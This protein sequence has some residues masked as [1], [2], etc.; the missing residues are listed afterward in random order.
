MGLKLNPSTSPPDAGSATEADTLRD[1]RRWLGPLLV[2]AVI[3][4]LAMLAQPSDQPA[5]NSANAA[6]ETAEG[7]ADGQGNT[8]AALARRQQDDPAALGKTDAP[9]VV[10]EYS[11][12]QCSFCSQHARVTSPRL[13]REYVDK[14]LVRI[15]WRDLP[16]L[17]PESRTAAAAGRAAGAQGKFWEFHDA[18]YARDGRGD[19]AALDDEALRAIATSIGLDLGRFEADRTSAA[20]HA[21]IERDTQEAISMGLTG[22]P[23]FIIGNTPIMGA[24]PYEVFQ[25]IIVEQ[26]AA[27]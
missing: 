8:F 18:V 3:A 21:A 2:I 15:E 13:I 4:M 17:G 10:I 11:D 5:G 19:S 24:Q 1:A 7:R 6:T 12:F 25:R 27:K 20:I 22:T 26:L 9:V 14:G 23:A 16:Y